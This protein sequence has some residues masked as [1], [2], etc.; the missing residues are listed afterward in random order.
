VVPFPW[1][2]RVP[3]VRDYQNTIRRNNSG[4]RFGFSSL[5]YVPLT[6]DVRRRAVEQLRRLAP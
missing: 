3:I 5:G 4:A 6:K 2:A 1:N